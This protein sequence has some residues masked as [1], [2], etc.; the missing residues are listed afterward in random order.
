[1][2]VLGLVVSTA[3]QLIFDTLHTVS[4]EFEIF[5]NSNHFELH[6]LNIDHEHTIAKVLEK[7]NTE[8]DGPGAVF[9]TTLKLNFIAE[10]VSEIHIVDPN[11]YKGLQEI[12][13]TDNF[14][15]IY[16]AGPFQP[17]QA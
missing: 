4:H 9:E 11:S 15:Q 14:Y 3:P 1:M 16:M 13:Y 17:P 12:P 2:S 5:S 7:Q 8:D 10:P 6:E